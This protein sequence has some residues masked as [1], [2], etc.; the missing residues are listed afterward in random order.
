[1]VRCCPA[2]LAALAFLAAVLCQDPKAARAAPPGGLESMEAPLAQWLMERDRPAAGTIASLAVDF[3]RAAPFRAM[4]TAAL[5]GDWAT[6]PEAARAAR[7]KAFVL[8]DKAAWHLVL[9]DAAGGL[10]PTVILAPAAKRDLVLQAPHPVL[11]RNT[12]PQTA[13]L[14]THLGGH[15]A[16]VAGAN[17]CAAA[18]ETACS[19]TTGIC[20]EWGKAAYR[21]SDVAH[22][23]E[24]LFHVAHEE[25]AARYPQ[26]LVVS[27]HGF[28][29]R[30]SAP[31]TWVVLSD[32]GKE[33]G[34]DAGNLTRRLR[35]K[36][37][38]NLDGGDARAV[39]CDD[40][41]DRR[42]NFPRLCAATN[43][44]GR[45]LNGSSDAC[46]QGIDRG[47]GRFLHVEQTREIRDTFADHWRA[48]REDAIARAVLD[49]FA[50]AIPCL[51]GRCP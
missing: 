20:K 47:T 46:R 40:L 24:T 4:V 19:G 11:D 33:E 18:R 9:D 26:A 43:V 35:D 39:A 34:G 45:H 21:D 6:L 31:D 51:P 48:P 42:F 32:G 22:N 28:A 13:V 2:A 37:R 27:V 29:K 50:A 38:A 49:A 1:M 7:Y 3:V 8:T 10:G 44:Q 15:A 12:V 23:T 17:R 30:P 16:I 14:L 5:A 36:L 25:L 41:D